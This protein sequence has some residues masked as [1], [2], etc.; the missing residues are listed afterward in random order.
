[1]SHRDTKHT[2]NMRSAECNLQPRVQL[3]WFLSLALMLCSACGADHPDPSGGTRAPE[4]KQAEAKHIILITV[5]AL[6]ADRLGCYGN[7]RAT[8]PAIDRLAAAGAIFVNASVPRAVTRPSMTSFFSSRYPSE[9]GVLTNRHRVPDDEKLLAEH[10]LEAQF[11][12]SAMVGASTLDSDRSNLGQGFNDF[13]LIGSDEQLTRSA[14]NYLRS[15]FARKD[16]R[17]F[18]WLH[19]MSTHLP[20]DPPAPYDS[21]FTDSNYAGH[22]DG[23]VE[24]LWNSFT[25]SE[26][27]EESDH[28]RVV[29]LYDGCVAAA[30]AWIERVIGALQA[31]GAEQDTLL[32]ITSDHGEELSDHNGFYGHRLSPYIA[33]LRVPMVFS[34]PGRIPT[35]TQVEGLMT[36]LDLLP[37]ALGWLGLP[38]SERARGYDQTASVLHGQA[39]GRQFAM[40]EMELEDDFVW[41]VRDQNWSWVYNPKELQFS[42]EHNG[43]TGTYPIPGEALYQV[44]ESRAEDSNALAQQRELA[45][46]MQAQWEEWRAAMARGDASIDLDSEFAEELEDLGYLGYED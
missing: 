24:T 43:S 7:E 22:A 12:T 13:K 29:D 21:R 8:S 3:V 23:R 35:G 37:T 10:L 14:E 41:G 31:S 4:Q 11:H 45:R 33:A 1:M 28:Q 25:G 20:Y 9:H 38:P 18:L 40:R 30:D 5:D 16:R 2:V 15:Q 36:S 17:E 39:S 42:F 44:N 6:R 26:P 34:Q 32:I 46:K 27:F 19:Y